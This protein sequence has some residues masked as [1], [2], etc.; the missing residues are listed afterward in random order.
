[1]KLAGNAAL[2][3]TKFIDYSNVYIGNGAKFSFENMVITSTHDEKDFSKVI[4][5]EVH[6]GNNTWITSR[7]T[8][9]GGSIIGDNS[10]IAA[11]SVVHGEIPPNTLAG[12]I[13]ARPLRKINVHYA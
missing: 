6:I 8:I 7:V 2:H 3:D 5:K 10:I 12:G 13:P 4:S 9:L 1:M 11:G